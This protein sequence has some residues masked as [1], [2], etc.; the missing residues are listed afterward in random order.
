MTYEI[1][2]SSRGVKRFLWTLVLSLLLILVVLFTTIIFIFPHYP[3]IDILDFKP[4]NSKPNIGDDGRM[5]TLWELNINVHNPNFYALDFEKIVLEAYIRN[6]R[7]AFSSTDN[8]LFRARSK[9]SLILNVFVPIEND[10]SK[11]NIMGE[12]LSNGSLDMDIIIGA[13][14]KVSDGFSV[15]LESKQE[16]RVPCGKSNLK[17]L[18]KNIDD[19]KEKR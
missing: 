14:R 12:C 4:Q 15:L 7:V 10:L 16:K 11:P 1:N 19:F 9:T 5:L 3:S 18:L 6:H 13:R 2:K 17:N 8:V